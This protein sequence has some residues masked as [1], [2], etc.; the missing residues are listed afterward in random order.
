MSCYHVANGG[1]R[2][3]VARGRRRTCAGGDEG[4]FS[5]ANLN[6]RNFLKVAATAAGTTILVG[7]GGTSTTTDAGSADATADAGSAAA[8][9]VTQLTF[10]PGKLTVATGNP[11]WEPWVKDDNPESGEGF[12]AAV[13]YAL[14]E[15]MGFASEDVVWVRTTFDEAYAPGDKEWDLNIQQVSIT[16]ER[17]QAVDFS[18]AYYRPTQS[19]IAKNDSAYAGATT[20][21][22]LADATFAVMV[23]TTAYDFVADIFK[24]G[25]DDGIEAYNNNSDAVAAVDAGQADVLVTDTPQCVYMVASEQITDGTVVGQI[26]GTE[27]PDGLG[28]VLP[29]GSDLT[30]YVTEA[31]NEL[32]DDGTI[33]GLIETW[34]TEY[35][36]VPMLSE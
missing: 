12:E 17:K 9:D 21:A 24:G 35:T 31:M 29:L 23:G 19:V 16:E 1:Q 3:C 11:A 4:V 10:E 18:P 13:I 14:A 7:C 6:R 28:I 30:A 15:K 27:D 8:G 2:L 22:D 34:L 25:S 26:P 32:L 33:D 20:V 36:S 5:M